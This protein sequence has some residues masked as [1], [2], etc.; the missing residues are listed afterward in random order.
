MS[1]EKRPEPGG[2]DH[3]SWKRAFLNG[4]IILQLYVIVFWGM[5]GSRFRN[6]MVQLVEPY[7]IKLGLWHSWDMFS[8]DP[9]AVNFNL[10]AHITFADGSLRIW[11]F[12]RMEKLGVWERYQKERF[13]KWRERVRQDVYRAVWDDTARYIARQVHDPANPPVKV[14]LVRHW[15]SIPPPEPDPEDKTQVRDYQ[16]IAREYPMPYNFR[17]AFYDVKPEDL[18]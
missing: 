2:A 8:P 18:R 4:F 7:V 9:L 15:G 10:E 6:L 12:P 1:K 11:E 14:V 17:F 16:P 3:A 13:R 5:P